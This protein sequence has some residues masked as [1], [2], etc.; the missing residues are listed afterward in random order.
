MRRMPKPGAKSPVFLRRLAGMDLE[1]LRFMLVAAG[2]IAVMVV[3]LMGYSGFFGYS[4]LPIA[5]ILVGYVVLMGPRFR[6]R[7]VPSEAVTASTRCCSSCSSDLDPSWTTCRYC[8]SCLSDATTHATHSREAQT[9]KERLG[10][11]FRLR[12]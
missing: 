8:G 5:F 6:K 1:N 3:A 11:H 10:K 2:V 4:P 7:K 9:K 12:Y